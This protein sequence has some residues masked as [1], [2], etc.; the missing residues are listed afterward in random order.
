ME[1]QEPFPGTGDDFFGNSDNE[2]IEDNG[3]TGSKPAG[4]LE[5]I[6]GSVA[7]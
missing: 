2:L 3:I 1:A 5:E 7:L 6:L 4:T